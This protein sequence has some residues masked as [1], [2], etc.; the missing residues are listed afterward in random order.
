MRD[1][2][3][4]NHNGL[5]SLFQRCHAMDVETMPD[6]DGDGFYIVAGFQQVVGAAGI[7]VCGV[8]CKEYARMGI[9]AVVQRLDQREG[10][11]PTE[12][13]HQG[14]GQDVDGRHG[15]LVVGLVVCFC[16]TSQ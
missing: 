13:N 12:T 11:A 9:A 2:N 3:T 14:K 7:G 8:G 4:A 6:P 16:D 5:A 15:F 10:I 1:M